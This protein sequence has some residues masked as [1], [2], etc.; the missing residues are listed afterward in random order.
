MS[1]LNNAS[2]LRDI[3]FLKEQSM[4]AFVQQGSSGP[5]SQSHD[6]WA[7]AVDT[8]MHRPDR[9]VRTPFSEPRLIFPHHLF[10]EH[11]LP[12]AGK[13]ATPGSCRFPG[14]CR[15]AKAPSPCRHSGQLRR[16]TRLQGSAWD[17]VTPPAQVRHRRVLMV[18]TPHRCWS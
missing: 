13:C 7:T 3:N 8:A 4:S 2:S 12:D 5:T 6:W 15:M 1:F 10:Q 17:R 11:W 14:Q 18:L 16:A 9:P